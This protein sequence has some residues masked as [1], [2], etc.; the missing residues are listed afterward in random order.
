[1]SGRVGLP[2]LNQYYKQGLMC[3]APGHNAVTPV[4]LE[5]A[6]LRSKVKHSR[7][8]SL[9]VFLKKDA[10]Q[11]VNQPNLIRVYVVHMP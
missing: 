10:E 3:L 11:T 6:A 1:M 8:S 9:I 2:G 7:L 4:R 5:P